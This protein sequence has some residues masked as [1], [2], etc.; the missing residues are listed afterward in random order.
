[1]RC[2]REAPDLG[3]LSR[4]PGLAETNSDADGLA[5]SGQIIFT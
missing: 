5:A 3:I 2:V 1:M 4:G